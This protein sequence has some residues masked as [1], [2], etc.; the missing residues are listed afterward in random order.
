[1]AATISPRLPGTWPDVALRS[2]ISNTVGWVRPG[3]LARHPARRGSGI[4]YLATLAADGIAIDLDRVTLSGTRPA[5]PRPVER[6][7]R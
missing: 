5:A 3:V 6:A 7:A 1:M 4:D 2:G